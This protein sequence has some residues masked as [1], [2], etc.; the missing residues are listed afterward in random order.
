M[1]SAD[2][3]GKYAMRY[4]LY[5]GFTQVIN[6]IILKFATMNLKNMQYTGGK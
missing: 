3:K 4:T 1:I 6:R 2:A 5:I